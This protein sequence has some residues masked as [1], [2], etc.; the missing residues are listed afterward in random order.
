L[1]IAAAI[2]HRRLDV[3]AGLTTAVGLS[4]HAWAGIS[5]EGVVSLRPVGHGTIFSAA[6]WLVTFCVS[7]IAVFAARGRSPMGIL[8]MAVSILGVCLL[9]TA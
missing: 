7:G 4:V 2:F 9:F 6:A 1:T 8:G 3:V 5:D